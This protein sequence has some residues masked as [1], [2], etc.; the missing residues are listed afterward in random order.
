M[1]LIYQI[2]DGARRLIGV[3]KERR[4]SSLQEWLE[5][6]GAVRCV[7]ITVVCSDMWPQYLRVIKRMLPQALNIGRSTLPGRFKPSASRENAKT[8]NY[9]LVDMTWQ[10]GYVVDCG[11][12]AGLRAP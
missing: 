3:V 12:E 6:F 7:A 4:E 5:S 10:T 1:T 11:A 8:S 2:N 9:I